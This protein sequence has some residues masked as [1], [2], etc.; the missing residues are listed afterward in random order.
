MD[1]AFAGANLLVACTKPSLEGCETKGVAIDGG[2]AKQNKWEFGEGVPHLFDSG[3]LGGGLWDGDDGNWSLRM[4][5][6]VG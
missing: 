1:P 5:L 3:G 2:G 4:A 6:L